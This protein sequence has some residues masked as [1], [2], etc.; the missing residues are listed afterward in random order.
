M[1]I[2]PD[3][4]DLHQSYFIFGMEIAPRK[5]VLRV[6]HQLLYLIKYAHN[7]INSV[8]DLFYIPYA[9]F[10][11][12]TYTFDTNVPVSVAFDISPG[13]YLIHGFVMIPSAK[14]TFDLELK[15]SYMN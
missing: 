14:Q 15:G 9:I 7:D 4:S 5:K 13:S 3:A 2:Y 12:R 1:M 11:A 6:Q 8:L 10:N